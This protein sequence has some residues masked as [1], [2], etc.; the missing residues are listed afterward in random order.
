MPTTKEQ[1]PN[2]SKAEAERAAVYS[3]VV[4][5]M[6]RRSPKEVFATLVEAGIYRRDGRL[7]K[8]YRRIC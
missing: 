7:T 1:R 5:D 4:R 8:P 2:G 3:K 6:R